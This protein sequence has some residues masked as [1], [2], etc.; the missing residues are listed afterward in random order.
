MIKLQEHRGLSSKNLLHESRY[1]I[2]K[3]I[4][5]IFNLACISLTIP[6]ISTLAVLVLP[7]VLKGLNLLNLP[8]YLFKTL[9]IQASMIALF[10]FTII[11]FYFSIYYYNLDGSDRLD[12]DFFSRVVVINFLYLT[13][14]SL[15]LTKIRFFPINFM[16]INVFLFSGG[17]VFIFMSI[18]KYLG[19]FNFS[20]QL[21]L[22][23]TRA[24]PSFW[25]FELESINGP[26]L[27][28]YSYLGLSFVGT[29]IFFSRFVRNCAGNRKLLLS[30]IFLFSIMFSSFFLAFYS[31]IALG[32]RTPIIAF[33]LSLATGLTVS[34]LSSSNSRK[35]NVIL[36]YCV[37]FIIVFV[38]FG[39]ISQYLVDQVYG[40]VDIGIG[41]RFVE[42]GFEA[43]SR[44]D[45]WQTVIKESFNFPFGGRKIP[46]P[47]VY[48][49]NIWLDQLNDS[50]VISM[51]LLFSYHTFQLLV[52]LKLVNSKIPAEFKAFILC[53][54]VAFL[55]A[56]LA[57]PV[58]QANY[59]YFAISC[60]FFG[61]TTRF[62]FDANQI[63]GTKLPGQ[64]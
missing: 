3:L 22:I 62:T 14:L 11:N 43:H 40:L 25:A 42:R 12:I 55:V 41:K 4:I 19:Y 32:A 46:L 18:V 39:L 34:T 50:G 31:S 5:L 21:I 56:F 63:M 49:H 20:P 59:V 57:T 17:V 1:G 52:I 48:A 6:T 45:L 24:V 27:D 36:S 15:N 54:S 10:L 9:I 26:S 8:K 58:I 44:T 61:S 29:I 13:G 51:I 53:T 37:I 33:L 64:K 2:I 16:V 28:I 47:T 60:F 38:V 7:I 30:V 35:V 23:A